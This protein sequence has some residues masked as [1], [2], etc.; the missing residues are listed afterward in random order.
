MS[1]PGLVVGAGLVPAR[2]RNRD[3]TVNPGRFVRYAW[4]VLGY[5][6]A[7]IMWGAYVR[8]SGSG[9]GCGSHWPLCNGTVIPRSPRLET[10]I[11]LT[12]RLTSG[13]ALLLVVGL[14]VW[15]F[16]AYP[17][18]SPVRYAAIASMLLI[19]TEA[20]I[21]AGLVLLEYVALNASIARAFWISGHLIN[22]FLLLAAL[23]LTAWWASGIEPPRGRLKGAIPW[24]LGIALV[25]LILLGVSG[26]IAA[27]GDTLFPAGS[28]AEGIRQDFSSTAHL[29]LRLRILHPFIAAVVG[30]GLIWTTWLVRERLTSPRVRRLGAVLMAVVVIQLAAGVVNIL[31][32][33]PIWMQLVHLLLSDVVWISFVLFG[34][35]TLAESEDST[36]E[37]EEVLFSSR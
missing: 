10:I 33:A 16:R 20:L 14:L 23:A 2:L 19:I 5:N 13:V 32:L 4:T 11:E 36:K 25:G 34:V 28:L 6:I 9:A 17:R 26:A 7:V 8:A 24:S 30:F 37:H 1:L 3:F 22:T 21:G 15:A 12:H 29:L 18:R 27:L 35:T 31:L